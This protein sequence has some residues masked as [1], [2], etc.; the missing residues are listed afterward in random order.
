MR[1]YFC[2]IVESFLGALF[3][4]LPGENQLLLELEKESNMIGIFLSCGAQDMKRKK[5]KTDQV[6]SLEMRPATTTMQQKGPGL[7]NI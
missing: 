7:V 2:N 6:L 1:I 3:S 5:N 4:I